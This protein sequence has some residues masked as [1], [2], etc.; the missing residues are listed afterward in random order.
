ML[1]AL[2]AFGIRC[3]MVA[4]FLPFSALDKILNFGQAVEQ[5]EE[6]IPG[7]WPATLLILG[8]LGVEIVM[9]MA[10]LTGVA[11][12]LAALVLAVYCIVTALLWKRFWMVRNFRLRGRRADRTLYWDFLKNLAVA[13][14]F[15]LL[16]FGP[17]AEGAKHFFAD[18]LASSHPY[19][20]PG[21]TP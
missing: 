11:D 2:I 9:S 15:M 3:L 10:V 18:P 5:A 16:A 1:S 19:S 20:A 12:R 6:V 21:S 4:L 8:G 7:K 13:G 14:G 17:D